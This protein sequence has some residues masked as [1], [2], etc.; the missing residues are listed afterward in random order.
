VLVSFG[1]AARA[2]AVIA[3]VQADGT[4]W[5]GPTTWHGV[6]AMRLRVSGWSTTDDDIDRSVAAVRPAAEAR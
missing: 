5:C 6:R 2:D 3:A 1:R 4:C